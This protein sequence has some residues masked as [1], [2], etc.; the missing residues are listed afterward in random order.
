[1]TDHPE[2]P[3]HPRREAFRLR[4]GLGLFVFSWLPIAQVVIAIVGWSD[5][6]ADTFRISVWIAQWII[7][8]VGLLIA[9][10]T[11]ATT[12]RKVGWRHT[13]KVLWRMLRSGHAESI[14]HEPPP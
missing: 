8:I 4:L 7:G 12:V 1:M 9:G 6:K 10:R 11:A 14:D 5:G 13:P 2:Q 3:D